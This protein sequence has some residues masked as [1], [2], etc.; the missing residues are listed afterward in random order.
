MDRQDR[1]RYIGNAL[2]DMV[3]RPL[4]S[5]TFC[6]KQQCKKYIPHQFEPARVCF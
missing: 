1:L 4:D 2:H 3:S 5:R 6:C